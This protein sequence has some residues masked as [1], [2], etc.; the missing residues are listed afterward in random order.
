VSSDDAKSGGL[1]H[2]FVSY[3]WEDGALAEWLT[4]KLTAEGY[5]VWCD[6]F[7]ILG[8]E[9]WPDDVDAAIRNE[10]FR[11]LHL[12]SK[13]SLRKPNPKK[14]RELALQLERT[15][16]VEILIPLNVDGTKP[17]DLPWRIVDVAYIPFQNWATGLAQ[18]LKKLRSVNAPRPVEDTGREIAG[19]AFLVRSPITEGGEELVSNV[20]PF[21][22]VPKA[23]RHFRLLPELAREHAWPLQKTWAFRNLGGRG[24]LAFTAPPA[25]LPKGLSAEETAR[26]A[27]QEGET[28]EGV[29]AEH[30]VSELLA[31]SLEL[32]CRMRGL[33][34]DPGGRGF[35]FPFGLLPNNKLFFEG[36]GGMRSTVLVCGY[37][38]FGG[39]KYRYHMGPWFRVRRDMGSGFVAQLRLRVHLADH[40]GT[41][42]E[43]RAA[44]ARRKK[45]GS[46]W[47][48]GQWLSRQLAVM[49]FLTGEQAEVRVGQ[50]PESQVVLG[51]WPMHRS[52]A[53]GIDETLLET[54]GAPLGL[55]APVADELGEEEE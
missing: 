41:P 7:K 29:L 23:L 27:W 16:G 37:R 8:G 19:S 47:W 21:T 6:R 51:A 15:R 30:L 32:H 4:L 17:S 35:Y 54:I 26:T 45:I 43:K 1:D 28:V 36:W 46:A 2:L 48:N 55:L 10:T 31:K 18:L 39:R 5:R 38:T 34:M 3:A 25:P 42:L 11:M 13:H 50:D 24:A 20:F 33:L 9:K 22:S 40:H 12:V 49:S 53:R 44:V 14:E 52:V